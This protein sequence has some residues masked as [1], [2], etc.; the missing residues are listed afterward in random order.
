MGWKFILLLNDVLS[1]TFKEVFHPPQPHCPKSSAYSS[2]SKNL[3]FHCILGKVLPASLWFF[4]PFPLEGHHFH[5]IS[6]SVRH[7]LALLQDFC[8]SSSP[9]CVNCLQ[10]LGSPTLERI[11]KVPQLNWFL[12]SIPILPLLPPAHQ[13]YI[14]PNWDQSF[15]S[16]R[17]SWTLNACPAEYWKIMELVIRGQPL[18]TK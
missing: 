11:P 1:E 7:I 10:A 18:P 16:G 9:E 2:P 8:M 6:I 5:P 12:S 13:I 4:P 17:I 14:P 3:L 15:S